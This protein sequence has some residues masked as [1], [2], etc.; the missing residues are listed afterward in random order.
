MKNEFLWMSDLTPEQLRVM[1]DHGTEPPGSSPLNYEKRSGTYLCAGCLTP[2]FYAEMK[3]DSG[4][5]WPSF[6]KVIDGAVETQ[7]DHSHHMVR[8]EVHCT[9]CKAHLGHV[10]PDGPQPTG[11]RFCINGVALKFKTEKS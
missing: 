2:L 10:F 1:R 3:Y 11:E 4:C 5:G 9:R 6:Y 7:I 8:T